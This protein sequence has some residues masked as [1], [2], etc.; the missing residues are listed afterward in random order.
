MDN[1]SS[2]QEPP[3][4][5]IAVDVAKC[6]GCGLC[7]STCPE[8]FELG[9]EDGKSHVK[10]ARGCEQCNCQEAIDSCPARAISWQEMANS[11]S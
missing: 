3:Q 1:Q 6:I 2:K 10:N 9:G 11:K 7:V 5:V 4:K 8:V